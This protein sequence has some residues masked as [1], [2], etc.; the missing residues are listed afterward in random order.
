M[1]IQRNAK[2]Q[3]RQRCHRLK[4]GSPPKPWLLPCRTVDGSCSSLWNKGF[5]FS[6]ATQPLGWTCLCPEK[7]EDANTS[8]VKMSGPILPLPVAPI[9]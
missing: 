4:T 7:E 8:Y 2:D 1:I 9:A 6:F 3:A 5:F